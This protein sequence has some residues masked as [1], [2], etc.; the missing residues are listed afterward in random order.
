MLILLMLC[1]ISLVGGEY[2]YVQR[3]KQMSR[4]IDT[5]VVP[6]MPQGDL[7]LVV[8]LADFADR[9]YSEAQATEIGRMMLV[10]VSCVEGRLYARLNGPGQTGE[11]LGERTAA[12]LAVVLESAGYES[13]V[14]ARVAP[15]QAIHPER[16]IDSTFDYMDD[17]TPWFRQL[18][19]GAEDTAL[20]IEAFTIFD[21]DAEFA[22]LLAD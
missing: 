3:L 21:I 17:I 9:P 11:A 20:T 12:L 4:E 2:T 15:I 16:P 18:L 5:L 1:V 8:E 10:D 14:R 6:D 13:E 19:H 7:A 22:A